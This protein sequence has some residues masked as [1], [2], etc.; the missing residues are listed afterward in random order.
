MNELSLWK[1]YTIW[2]LC[3]LTLPGFFCYAILMLALA[4]YVVIFIVRFFG[5]RFEY[6]QH[7]KVDKA[8]ARCNTF[9]DC[10]T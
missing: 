2:I 3:T 10:D 5:D 6:T 7:A 4:V 9:S 8:G 1:R